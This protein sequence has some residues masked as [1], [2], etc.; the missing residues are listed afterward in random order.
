MARNGMRAG[1]LGF[2]ALRPH[3]REA[4][5]LKAEAARCRAMGGRSGERVYFVGSGVSF[6]ANQFLSAR[7]MYSAS[8]LR[9]SV[10]QYLV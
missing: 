5:T 7:L 3:S 6:T 4:H 9:H 8:F 10:V 1:P 2:L